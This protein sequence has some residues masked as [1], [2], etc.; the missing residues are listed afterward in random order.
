[1]RTWNCTQE[2]LDIEGTVR[3]RQLLSFRLALGGWGCGAPFGL[4]LP[5]FGPVGQI[6]SHEFGK[7]ILVGVALFRCRFPEGSNLQAAATSRERLVDVGFDARVEGRCQRAE[8]RQIPRE[9]GPHRTTFWWQCLASADVER[10]FLQGVV[11]PSFH[12]RI[13]PSLDPNVVHLLASHSL[14]HQ[15][16]SSLAQNLRSPGFCSFVVPFPL[17]AHFCRCG[18]PLDVRG[19]HRSAG[20]G[21]GT[22]RVPAGECSSSRL[23][24][25]RGGSQSTSAWL[26]S[27]FFRQGGKTVEWMTCMGG[28][29]RWPR[30]GVNLAWCPGHRAAPDRRHPA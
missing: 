11:W 4:R 13:E 2:L 27:I 22:S 28:A 25:G 24:R 10:T 29:D 20:R 26:I 9:Q 23:L 14:V 12:R 15:W 30:C 17:S 21:V 16:W 3:V 5:R 19:H 6:H 1:M 7:G 8:T 18:R